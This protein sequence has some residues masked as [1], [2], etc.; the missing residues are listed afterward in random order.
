VRRLA[1]AFGLE[2]RALGAVSGKMSLAG[3]PEDLGTPDAHGRFDPHLELSGRLRPS[4]EDKL[5]GVVG[6]VTEVCVPCGVSGSQRAQAGVDRDESAIDAVQL[7]AGHWL[8]PVPLSPSASRPADPANSGRPGVQLYEEAVRRR[9][10]RPVTAEVVGP[11]EP[12]LF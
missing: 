6:V 7:T 9:P 8:L 4:D 11:D 3:S 10:A 5:L 12:S 2:Q 1:S